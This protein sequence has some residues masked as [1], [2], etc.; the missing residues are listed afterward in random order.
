MSA[1]EARAAE[2]GA[3]LE[4]PLAGSIFLPEVRF[5]PRRSGLLPVARRLGGE[6]D[7]PPGVFFYPSVS[8][9]FTTPTS[10]PAACGCPG[11]LRP[12]GVRVPGSH[13]TKGPRGAS[14]R[15]GHGRRGPASALPPWAP[16]RGAR[17][18]T[19]T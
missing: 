17:V 5:P 16:E 6:G 19:M 10:V 15:A 11:A 8:G 7:P 2:G 14:A 1:S 13:G 18:A 12:G 4:F 9:R 3:G